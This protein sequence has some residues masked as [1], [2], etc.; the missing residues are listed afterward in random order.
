M[1]DTFGSIGYLLFGL[2]IITKIYRRVMLFLK[3]SN[4][5]LRILLF[6]LLTWLVIK[7]SS[8]LDFSEAVENT[9]GLVFIVTYV[10]PAAVG[11]FAKGNKTSPFD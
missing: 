8:Y 10:I 1:F 7:T 5:I 11:F 6:M 2:F 9:I 4:I 3:P